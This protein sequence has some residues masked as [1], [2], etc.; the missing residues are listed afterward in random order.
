MASSWKLIAF[1]RKDMSLSE[2]MVG[3]KPLGVTRARNS[4]VAQNLCAMEGQNQL[5][6]RTNTGDFGSSG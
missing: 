3:C 2:V 5:I 4:L 1:F 6:T